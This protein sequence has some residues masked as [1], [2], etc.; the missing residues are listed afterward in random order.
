VLADHAQGKNR[1]YRFFDADEDRSRFDVAQIT[2]GRN[3]YGIGLVPDPAVRKARWQFQSLLAD[4][5]VI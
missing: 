1:R 2:V 3:L 5:G 4:H